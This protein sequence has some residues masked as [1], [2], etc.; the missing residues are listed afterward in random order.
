MRAT[1]ILCWLTL[2]LIAGKALSPFY[3]DGPLLTAVPS[4]EVEK[5]IFKQN[6]RHFADGKREEAPSQRLVVRT[7]RPYKRACPTRRVP[8]FISWAITISIYAP[9]FAYRCEIVSRTLS[10]IS[11]SDVSAG[12]TSSRENRRYFHR[13][14]TSLRRKWSHGR[15][16]RR[17][18]ASSASSDCFSLLF[19]V[20]IFCFCFFFFFLDKELKV[21]GVS[22]EG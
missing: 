19:S 17:V 11:V 13:V 2:L 3:R 12:T 10:L 4:N 7:P 21:Q 14:E 22:D 15:V 1:R 16:T 20:G 6:W 5:K 8:E 9:R 18:N